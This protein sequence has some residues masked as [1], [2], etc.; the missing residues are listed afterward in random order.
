MKCIWLYSNISLWICVMVAITE[1][2]IAD[3]LEIMCQLWLV[4]PFK[5]SRQ[6]DLDPIFHWGRILVVFCLVCTPF[7]VHLCDRLIQ[8]CS[9]G[10]DEMRCFFFAALA[11]LAGVSDSMVPHWDCAFT[12]PYSTE[13]VNGVSWRNWCSE[14]SMLLLYRLD[15]GQKAHLSWSL[16]FGVLGVVW[17]CWFAFIVIIEGANLIKPV[18]NVLVML[19]PKFRGKKYK[20]VL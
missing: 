9:W 6:K 19:H 2:S 17:N 13:Q 11:T 18:K 1:N 12:S 4:L 7:L 16:W 20:T 8:V 10:P 3:R 5:M 15:G 14:V